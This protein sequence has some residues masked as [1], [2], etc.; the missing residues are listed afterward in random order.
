MAEHPIRHTTQRRRA[1]SLSSPQAR[2]VHARFIP[3]RLRSELLARPRIY[4]LFNRIL[5]YPLTLIKA[6]AGYGKT[7]AIAAFLAQSDLQCGWYSIGESGVEPLAF[8]RHLFHV[9]IL[10]SP[11]LKP[12]I[13]HSLEQVEHQALPWT[14]AIDV[15]ANELLDSLESETVL[16]L[17]DYDMAN[18][19]DISRITSRFIEHMPPQLHLVITTRITPGLPGLARWRASGELLEINRTHLA[20]TPDEIAAFCAIHISHSLSPA[21]L[22]FLASETEGWPIA[23]QML[24]KRLE[25]MLSPGVDDVL[26]RL[27]DR[28]ERLFDYLAV[29]VLLR[30]PRDIQRFLAVTACLRRL[31]PEV[32]DALPGIQNSTRILRSLEEGSLFVTHDGVYRYHRLFRDFLLRRG[33]ILAEEQRELYRAAATCYRVSGDNEEAIYHSLMAG[34][35]EAAAELLTPVAYMFAS[36]GRH[37]MLAAWFEQLPAHLLEAS[38]ELLLAQGDAARFTSH[39]S[40][41]LAIYIRAE[42]GFQQRGNAAG[43]A[44]ALQGQILIYLDTVQPA[45]AE[46]L[47]QRARRASRHGARED[48]L[49]LLRLLAENRLNAGKLHSAARLF[50]YLAQ[51]DPHAIDPRLSLRE[52]HFIQAQRSVEARLRADPAGIGLERAPRSHREPTAMLAWIDVM[53]GAAERARQYAEQSLEFGQALASPIIECISQAR[54]GHAW[55]SGMHYDLTR[56]RHH[57]QDSL[58]IAERIGVARF[59]VEA[60]LGLTLIAGLEEQMLEAE[61]YAQEG[62][63]ILEAAGDWYLLALLFLAL[64]IAYTLCDR[65]EAEGRLQQA[66][67]QARLCG[68]HFCGCAADLWLALYLVRAGRSDDARAS[69]L[70]ALRAGQD[71]GYDFLFVSAPL[72]GSKESNLR[73]ALLVSVQENPA[74]GK[75]VAHLM[76][77]LNKAAGTIQVQG[78]RYAQPTI[79]PLSI[80]TLGTFRVWRAGEEKQRTAW[81]REKALHLLQFLICHRDNPVHREQILEAL[82]PESTPPQ[83]AI[84]LRVA[85]NAL[86]S[87]LELGQRS[88]EN[89]QFIRRYGEMLWLDL[90]AG[91]VIDSDQFVQ[92]LQKARRA[93][94][95][96]ISQAITLYEAALQLYHGDF[97]I[98]LPYADWAYGEREQRRMQYLVT[99]ERLA[100]FALERGEHERAIE[101]ANTIL[102]KDPTWEAAYALLMECH[103]QQGNRALA[104][105]VYDRCRKRLSEML[106]VEP[107][108]DT[109]ALF[110]KVVHG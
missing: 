83:A 105:R 9:F 90:D 75:Y 101:W 57:Y 37:Q 8:L 104:V 27:P 100:R 7:T 13:M 20:F 103:W 85:L 33:G 12:R 92:L 61:A 66:T 46:P 81:G 35:N 87:A 98:E 49:N 107:S 110:E 44:R 72:L 4:T 21:V 77:L 40:Q 31:D 60:L 48:R 17:D 84:G 80:Q 70:R 42:E 18:S 97:L 1:T 38:P 45:L 108:P 23:V 25:G 88:A 5:E 2:V 32:C 30:Q 82:W 89:I 59:K 91:V 76:R 93:E 34:D 64:G 69:F 26:R 29:E 71:Y 47:L 28:T 78:E 3:P 6:E 58:V 56:A 65:A 53:T 19:P 94:R 62:F 68:D 79:A 41:A 15:L 86:R 95:G 63:A 96:D 67:H 36:N 99:V 24:G 52:G 109:T 54:L 102:R 16:V 51:G 39:Y 106:G 55:L 22:H 43:Q 14:L 11:T 10:I 73:V 74:L 50:R